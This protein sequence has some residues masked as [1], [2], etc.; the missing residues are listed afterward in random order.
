MDTCAFD[1]P[2]GETVRFDAEGRAELNDGVCAAFVGGP[3]GTV[4]GRIVVTDRRLAFCPVVG[5]PHPQRIDRLR[6]ASWRVDAVQ[7]RFLGLF[8]R[9]GPVVEVRWTWAGRELVL[10]LQVADP[11]ALVAALRA[12]VAG[13][14]DAR[15]GLAAALA[16]EVRDPGAYRELLAT[17]AFPQGFWH[18]EALDDLVE[19]VVDAFEA[20]GVGLD[21]AWVQSLD[22]DVEA[23]YGPEDYET[24][25]GSEAWA[26]KEQIERLCVAANAVLEG[27]R[28]F[29]RFA[30]DLPDWA[31]DEPVWLYLDEGER[32]ALLR[33]GVLR[34][35]QRG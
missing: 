22:L 19:V 12:P 3:S 32:E 10:P 20:L 5:Q 21:G 17:L 16:A 35:A 24:G 28:R 4:P 33:L 7:R 11:D 13:R 23:M 29:H 2:F 25:P 26:R 18:T 34:A 1:L 30:E 14:L 6:D 15:A 31:F 27:S 9:G 8:P